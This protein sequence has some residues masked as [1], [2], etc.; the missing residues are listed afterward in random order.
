MATLDAAAQKKII[1][2]VT[3]HSQLVMATRPSGDNAAAPQ[4]VLLRAVSSTTGSGDNVSLE[5]EI[6]GR[7]GSTFYLPST[8]GQRVIVELRL[9]GG[10]MDQALAMP[11][12][13]PQAYDVDGMIALMPYPNKI[14]L[15][16]QKLSLELKIPSSVDTIHNP[17]ASGIQK[18]NALTNI[19]LVLRQGSRHPDLATDP[20]T[21]ALLRNNCVSLLAGR[22]LD[23]SSQ[24][25]SEFRAKAMDQTKEVGSLFLSLCY[26][27]CADIGRA[28]SCHPLC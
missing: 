11:H 17:S 21:R 2:N 12:E 22:L 23:T 9:S 28:S 19:I 18:R 24:K 27:L 25:A 1:A 20:D 4:R 13:L 6:I 8:G 15:F 10:S 7:P 5:V 26:S 3:K 14:E 16:E